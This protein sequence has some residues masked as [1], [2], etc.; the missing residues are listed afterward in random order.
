M[1][2]QLPTF[3]D[4]IGYFVCHKYKTEFDMGLCAM[5]VIVVLAAWLFM[6]RP[7]KKKKNGGDD[8]NKK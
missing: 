3:F 6:S 7:K 2:N 4:R 1:N 8:G 5:A